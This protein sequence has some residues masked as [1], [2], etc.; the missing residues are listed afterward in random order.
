[1]SLTS[2]KIILSVRRLFCHSFCF[3]LVR[4]C[5]QFQLFFLKK[6]CK[7]K[8]VRVEDFRGCPMVKTLGFHCRGHGFTPSQNTACYVAKQKKKKKTRKIPSFHKSRRYKWWQHS[9]WVL[10]CFQLPKVYHF[11]CLV[12]NFPG[13][14][15]YHTSV[16]PH[17][18]GGCLNCLCLSVFSK[19]LRAYLRYTITSSSSFLL[20]SLLPTLAVRVNHQDVNP[21]SYIYIYMPLLSEWE[22]VWMLAIKDV[23]SLSWS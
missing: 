13:N 23:L 10:G 4:F 12:S 1:M 5:S 8:K 9:H 14:L 21:F 22:K 2:W 3:S 7:A 11:Q 19:N 15:F 6:R 17:L 18:T 16:H 20:L